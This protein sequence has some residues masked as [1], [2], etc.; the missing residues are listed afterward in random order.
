MK[1]RIFR[2]ILVAVSGTV[3]VGVILLTVLRGGPP[4]GTPEATEQ[5]KSVTENNDTSDI[6]EERQTQADPGGITFKAKGSYF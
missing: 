6:K 3:L 1:E 2:T 4:S 5:D